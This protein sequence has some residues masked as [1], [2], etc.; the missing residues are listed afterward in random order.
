MGEARKVGGRQLIKHI[1]ET[2]TNCAS[3]STYTYGIEFDG[4]I[5]GDISLRNLQEVAIDP[6]EIGYWISK[7]YAGKGLTTLATQALTS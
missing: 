6:P 7:D 1:E 2:L 3:N 4:E 5:V